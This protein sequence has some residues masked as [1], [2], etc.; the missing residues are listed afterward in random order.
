MKQAVILSLLLFSLKAFSQNSFY[1]SIKIY[2]QARID[3]IASLLTVNKGDFIAEIGSG[4]GNSL[5][6]LTKQFSDI[7]LFAE[8]IDSSKCNKKVFAKLLRANKS[9]TLIDSFHFVYGTDSNTTLPKH[10]FDKILLIAVIH[11][12]NKR[13]EMLV[14]IKSLLKTNGEILIEEPL[15]HKPILKDKGCNN[16]Y[17]T[18]ASLLNILSENDIIIVREKTIKDVDKTNNKFR[19]VYLCKLKNYS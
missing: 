16:P 8:D 12:F 19:K 9:Q 18:E 7:S 14:E 3:T 13:K 6:R 15:V 2:R 1:D 5:I 17:L 4:N 10:H 11:E